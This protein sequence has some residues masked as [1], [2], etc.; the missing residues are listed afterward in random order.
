MVRY[1]RWIMVLSPV[2][3]KPPHN[4]V[5]SIDLVMSTTQ[6][7]DLVKPNRNSA[8]AMANASS[9]QGQLSAW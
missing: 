2:G 9:R 5:G 1:P 4:G 3:L 6:S 7:L 8:R